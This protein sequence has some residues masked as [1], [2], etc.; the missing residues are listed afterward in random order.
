MQILLSSMVPR[1]LSD[2]DHLEFVSLP[3]H[4][5]QLHRLL[6]LLHLPLPGRPGHAN[7]RCLRLLHRPKH[8][9]A[10]LSLM[11]PPPQKF[12]RFHLPPQFFH[13][14]PLLLLRRPAPL[15]IRALYVATRATS[16][17]QGD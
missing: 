11:L 1:P 9:G 16:S 13:L 5:L 12:L 6:L 14:F 7:K 10:N 2:Q 4:L 15:P 17:P 3:T 8:A